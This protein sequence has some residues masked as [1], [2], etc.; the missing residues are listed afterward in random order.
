MSAGAPLRIYID[1]N[2][3]ICIVE[4][5]EPF[6]SHLGNLVDAMDDGRIRGVTSELTIT[7]IMVK[8]Y[9]DGTQHYIDEYTRLFSGD[10]LIEMRPVERLVLDRSARLRAKMGGRLADA[11]HVATAELSGCS[12]LLSEDAGIKVPPGIKPTSANRFPDVL[13]ALP[14]MP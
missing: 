3:L 12:H 5:K 13:A 1:T 11:I 14:E 2:I 8:P 9:A 10:S 7:E 6:R 4:G